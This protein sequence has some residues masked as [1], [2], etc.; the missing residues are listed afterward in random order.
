MD[1]EF[2]DIPHA[3]QI[4]QYFLDIITVMYVYYFLDKRCVHPDHMRG[5][6]GHDE[7]WNVK[8]SE[9]CLCSHYNIT[10]H[11]QD[12]DAVGKFE[13][14]KIIFNWYNLIFGNFLF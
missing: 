4:G 8:F 10:N 14:N 9:E 13:H 5:G 1:Q 2:L 3:M 11:W 7:P 12:G 6:G